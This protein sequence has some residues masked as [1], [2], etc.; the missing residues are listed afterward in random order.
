VLPV[1]AVCWRIHRVRGYARP[2]LNVDNAPLHPRRLNLALI[3]ADTSLG[4]T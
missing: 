2:D 4:I 1:K 3:R